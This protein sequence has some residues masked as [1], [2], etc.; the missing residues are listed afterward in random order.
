MRRTVLLGALAPLAFLFGGCGDDG[1]PCQC[2]AEGVIACGHRGTGVTGAANEFP[3]NTL[4]SFEQAALEGADMVELDVQ[5]SADGALVVVHDDTVDRTTDAT[6]CVGDHTLAELQALDAAVGTPL[7]GQGVTVPTLAEVLAAVDLPVNVEIK[8]NEDADCPASDR[9]TLAS[10]VVA[11]IQAD[12]AAREIV[13]SSFDLDVLIEVR[14]LDPG[15]SLGLLTLVPGDTAD[16]VANDL[17]AVNLFGATYGQAELDVVLDA[18][19]ELNVW[20]IND[21]DRMAELLG[22]GVHMVITDE[23]DLMVQV[24][25][26]WCESFC[27]VA[28]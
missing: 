21:P 25:Q 9:P 12:T 27:A 15:V 3:E 23:P 8:V 4:P 26:T 28:D 13:V 24:R 5:H 14:A 18:G 6:G 10:D 20:T 19:L 7:A 11:A 17:D 16:A 22:M 2:P 1:A